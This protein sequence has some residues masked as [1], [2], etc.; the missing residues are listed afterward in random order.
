MELKRWQAQAV[1]DDIHRARSRYSKEHSN[2]IINKH[3][4][5]QIF[6]T[7]GKGKYMAYLAY[8]VDVIHK[9][10]N[11]DYISIIDYFPSRRRRRKLGFK[12]GIGTIYLKDI[13][14]GLKELGYSV[15]I[16]YHHTY[17]S[18][19]KSYSLIKGLHVGWEPKIA[20]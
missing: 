18:E 3:I 9:D 7:A 20:D 5:P 16:E 19:Q 4:L 17:S 10:A 15:I 2:L 14:N 8:D 13:V 11:G 12:K 6:E 1:A